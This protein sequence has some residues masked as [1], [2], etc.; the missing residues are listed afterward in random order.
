MGLGPRE[1]R[2][3]FLVKFLLARDDLAPRTGDGSR[4]QGAGG[5][6]QR[7]RNCGDPRILHGSGAAATAG[8]VERARSG[9]PDCRASASH[10]RQE[11]D[12]VVK[13]QEELSRQAMA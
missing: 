4:Q 1:A 10:L 5:I 2:E 6:R 9:T 8:K 3:S 13:T 11:A 7:G 12:R